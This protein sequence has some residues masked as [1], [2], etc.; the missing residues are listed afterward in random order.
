MWAPESTCPT[1]AETGVPR[2]PRCAAY[3]ESSLDSAGDG[4]TDPAAVRDGGGGVPGQ[5]LARTSLALAFARASAQSRKDKLDKLT[6][7]TDSATATDRHGNVSGRPQSGPRAVTA[8]PESVD[9]YCLPRRREN[10]PELD[11][12]D[13]HQGDDATNWLRE[14][15]T[16]GRPTIGPPERKGATQRRTASNPL[17]KT[18]H[19]QLS[20]RDYET[21]DRRSEAE[22][23]GKPVGLQSA[24][25]RVART[26]PG[27]D[28]LA[29]ISTATADQKGETTANSVASHGSRRVWNTSS[30]FDIAK[31]DILPP[32]APVVIDKMRRPKVTVNRL[33]S[34]GSGVYKAEARM[35]RLQPAGKSVVA[36][37]RKSI[38]VSIGWG[39]RS[40]VSSAGDR[41]RNYTGESGARTEQ[42][43]P[44]R[45]AVAGN[46]ERR[47][48]PVPW[49][50]ERRPSDRSCSRSAT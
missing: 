13:P 44:A 4:P 24:E 37:A 27:T 5:R 47:V 29:A 21:S 1:E 12:S 46:G 6:R 41:E 34:P 50:N 2:L 35:G 14:S 39:R 17:Q 43:S 31:C 18:D 40:P 3:W 38:L 19:C 20:D 7:A 48:D 23:V 36:G 22:T 8:R 25:P 49:S 10:D 9:S 30:R 33:T 32:K 26:G 16:N 45:R 28:S 11:D 15:A 42:S